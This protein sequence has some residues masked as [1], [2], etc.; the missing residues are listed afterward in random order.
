MKKILG[1]SVLLS[2]SLLTGCA[3]SRSEVKLNTPVMGA[4]ES[5]L[6]ATAPTAA[7]QV[8]LDERK[9]EQA[10]S[11][12]GIPSLGFEGSA[13][14]T[15]GV[16][17]RAIARK[18]NGFGQAMGDVLLQDGQTV[19]NVVRDNLTVALRQAGYRVVDVASATERTMILDVHVKQ[20]WAWMQPGFWA[21]TMHGDIETDLNSSSAT[22]GPTNIIVHHTE[23]RQIATD[24]T[25]IE[26]VNKALEK[27]RAEVVQKLS[28][29][30]TAH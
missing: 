6:P 18:R 1:L 22:A 9:F 2:V 30:D 21:L 28:A 4:T 25:W 26:V 13:S 7:I 5:S 24:G 14:A 23:S 12:P 8:I 20:F 17:S 16:K 29:K 10:P 19:E 15:A 27:Y 11:N 3:T